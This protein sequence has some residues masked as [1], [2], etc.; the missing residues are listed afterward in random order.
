MALLPKTSTS[1]SSRAR[2]TPNYLGR[3][4]GKTEIFA[5]LREDGGFLRTEAG[6]KIVLSGDE[7]GTRYTAIAKP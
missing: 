5:L 2:T 4:K 7:V 6:G 3:D 1:Y